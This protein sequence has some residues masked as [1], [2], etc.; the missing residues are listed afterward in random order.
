MDQP[1]IHQAAAALL[2]ELGLRRPVLRAEGPAR[3]VTRAPL[4]AGLTE[5]AARLAALP[6]LAEVAVRPGGHLALRLAPQ[7]WAAA[8]RAARSYA[9]TGAIAPPSLRFTL[10]GKSCPVETVSPALRRSAILAVTSRNQAPLS[11]ESLTDPGYDNPVF[12]VYF[13]LARTQA[14][15][16]RPAFAEGHAEPDRLLASPGR[17]AFDLAARWPLALDGA[18]GDAA[19]LARHL[20]ALAAAALPALRPGADDGTRDALAA[21]VADVLRTG[22]QALGLPPSEDDVR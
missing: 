14:W 3:L 15:L 6:G 17:E 13:A 2:A 7:A 9:P 18:G 19:P 11:M 22:L 10:G 20:S 12:V 1:T 21:T 8:I 16:D 5:A 4:A